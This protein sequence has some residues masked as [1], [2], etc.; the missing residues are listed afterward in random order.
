MPEWGIAGPGEIG[1]SLPLSSIG[2]PRPAEESGDTK[3]GA[4]AR[5]S[6]GE[7]PWLRMLEVHCH[8]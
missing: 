6:E 1:S 7:D 4:E 5:S 2:D 8:Q 3:R